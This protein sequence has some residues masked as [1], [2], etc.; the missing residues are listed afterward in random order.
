MVIAALLAVLFGGFV[1]LELRRKGYTADEMDWNHDGVTTILEYAEVIDTGVLLVTR[2]QLICER[3]IWFKDGRVIKE[4]CR[5]AE[6][7]VK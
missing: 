5:L 2:E 1:L 7:E 3:H 4:V 6:P